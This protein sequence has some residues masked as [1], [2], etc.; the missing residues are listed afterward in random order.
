MAT[1]LQL[2]HS[3]RAEIIKKA[4]IFKRAKILKR[5][6]I[7]KRADIL[8]KGFFS[9]FLHQKSLYLTFSAHFG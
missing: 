1:P 3:L 2:L 6:E 5:A 8:K 7:H 4:D 9:E